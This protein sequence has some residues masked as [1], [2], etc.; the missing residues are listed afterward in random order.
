MP[1]LFIRE[2]LFF[3]FLFLCKVM[4]LGDL[5]KLGNYRHFIH[6]YGMVI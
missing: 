3:T 5:I 1:L 4:Y 2:M 6:I